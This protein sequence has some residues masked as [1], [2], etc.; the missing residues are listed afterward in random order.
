MKIRASSAALVLVCLISACAARRPQASASLTIPKAASA[1]TAE[2]PLPS[3]SLALA[4]EAVRTGI[5]RETYQ[6]TLHSLTGLMLMHEPVVTRELERRLQ[7]V[8]DEA[9]PYDLMVERLA[10]ILA[11]SYSLEELRF[12]VQFRRSPVQG[13]IQQVV[14]EVTRALQPG[15]ELEPVIQERMRAALARQGIAL[16]TEAPTNPRAVP[17]LAAHPPVDDQRLA[18]ARSLNPDDVMRPLIEQFRDATTQSAVERFAKQINPK[19]PQRE[20][21]R[22]QA[23][24]A[25]ALSY[26]EIRDLVAWLYARRLSLGELQ[27]AVEFQRSPVGQKAL[28][29]APTH[30]REGQAAMGDLIK[31]RFEPAIRK[32]VHQAPRRPAPPPEERPRYER[33]CESGGAEACN[34]LARSLSAGSG[35][36]NRVRARKLFERACSQGS[37]DACWSLGGLFEQDPVTPSSSRR[38]DELYERSCAL[39]AAGGCTSH[40]FRLERGR[41]DQPAAD[42]AYEKGCALGSGLGCGNRGYH[43]TLSNDP[44]DL[45]QANLLFE[46]GCNLDDGRSCARLGQSYADAR[47]A[48]RD[49]QRANELFER[50][51][52]DYGDGW[53]CSMLAF[54]Y[55]EGKGEQSDGTVARALYDKGCKLGNG[56]ACSNLG[57]LFADGTG[58]AADQKRATELYRKGCD[59][60]AAAGC[61]KLGV[62]LDLARGLERDLPRANELYEKACSLNDGEGCGNL[63]FNLVSGF[64]V[65]EDVDRALRLF[66]KGCE[67][68]NARSCHLRADHAPAGEAR[69]RV[70]AFLDKACSLSDW[71]CNDLG[72]RFANGDG[73]PK[74]LRRAATLYEKACERQNGLACSNLASA[75]WDGA[76]VER[77]RSHAVRLLRRGCELGSAGSCGSLPSQPGPPPPQPTLAPRAP[78]T[79]EAARALLGEALAQIDKSQFDAASLWLKVVLESPTFEALASG[80]RHAALT[81]AGFAAQQLDRLPQAAPVL[82]RATEMTEATL[83]DWY[84]L[85]QSIW[86]AD[87][88]SERVRILTAIARRWPESVP[89]LSDAAMFKVAREAAERPPAA[90]LELLDALFSA[91]WKTSSGVEPSWAWKDLALLLLEQG[92]KQ[93]AIEVARHVTSAAVLISFHADS[94]FDAVVNAE[95]AQFDVDAAHVREVAA[96]RAAVL[97]S[98]RSLR[99]LL[100]LLNALHA[101]RRFDEVAEMTNDVLQRA[102]DE[103]AFSD[104]DVLVWIR[105]GRAIALEGLGRWDEAVEEMRRASVMKEDGGPNVSQGINLASLYVRLDRPTEALTAVE[106]LG[107]MSNYGRME[108]ESVRH[109][110]GQ[111]L[112]DKAVAARALSYLREHKADAPILFLNAL[113][114]Q[115]E[116][117][118]ASAE[119]R[120]QLASPTLRSDMLTHLQGYAPLPKTPRVKQWQAQ[121]SALVQRPEVADA[122]ANVGR[123]LEWNLAP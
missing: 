25:E 107:A 84:L 29:L 67:L 21:P 39:G 103:G 5:S 50:A 64:G 105:N 35:V 52:D 19:D 16:G 73:I 122:I 78:E 43:Y 36:E 33:E 10:P 91:G 113:V 37:G 56:T 20:I 87:A 79:V 98:P 6:V 58:G 12:L 90:R 68:G 82:R 70:T 2:A 118:D 66:E 40:G 51:C 114:I 23:A 32:E 41:S 72:V 86:S 120:S 27:T 109:K 96:L 34:D 14:R 83:L 3:D 11:S 81:A 4:Q 112:G 119:L 89:P 123:V 100:P 93:R 28:R 65:H 62:A 38:I 30:L 42:R 46:K 63:G 97:K 94:R 116:M 75:Y 55:E 9:A 104:A 102:A 117:D 80:D 92:K 71:D 48:A 7:R 13:K 121:W 8:C 31:E 110:A 54:S 99:T 106:H 88:G 53:G 115:G 74:D 60:D 18:L 76:G 24:F 111:E 57:T 26:E 15:G 61:R 49:W 101:G 108:L 95:P 77:D 1:P 85:L 45:T 17:G 44:R 22:L 69:E 47:G 59:L